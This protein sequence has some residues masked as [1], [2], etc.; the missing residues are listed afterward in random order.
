MQTRFRLKSALLDEIDRGLKFCQKVSK[1][2][3]N[4]KICEWKRILVLVWMVDELSPT[5]QEK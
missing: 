1:I 2:C 4:M 5:F 3:R